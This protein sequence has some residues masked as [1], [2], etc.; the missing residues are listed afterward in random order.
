MRLFYFQII[1]LFL[2]SIT[3]GLAQNHLWS[4]NIGGGLDDVGRMTFN[5]NKFNDNR[6]LENG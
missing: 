1:V 2:L 4:F 6:I 5:D 3:K